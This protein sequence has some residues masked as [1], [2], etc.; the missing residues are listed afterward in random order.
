MIKFFPGSKEDLLLSCN[1]VVVQYDSQSWTVSVCPQHWFLGNIFL[2]S[3]DKG[4]LPTFNIIA[5][6]DL[7]GFTYLLGKFK[8]SLKVFV[9]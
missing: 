2:K 4:A 8:Y 9:A 5:F 7:L 6:K 1:A 3:W